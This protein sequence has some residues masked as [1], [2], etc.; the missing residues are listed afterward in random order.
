MTARR[1]TVI[2][3]G[4]AGVTV[5]LYLRLAPLQ[6]GAVADVRSLRVPFV[7]GWVGLLALLGVVAAWLPLMPLRTGLLAFS[8][9][10]LI[11]IGILGAFSID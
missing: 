11:G 5:A 7:L 2:S 9:A 3:A 4:L 6:P 1:L 8:A 10:G